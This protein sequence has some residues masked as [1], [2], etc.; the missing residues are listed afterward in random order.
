MEVDQ[1]GDHRH[2]RARP[3]ALA[4]RLVRDVVEQWMHRQHDVG[5]VLLQQVAQ[6]PAHGRAE[7]RSNG[8]ERRLRV[9]RVIDG[10]PRGARAADHGRVERGEA[11]D[12]GRSLPDQ[13]IGD[14]H[15]AGRVEQLQR[16]G[17]C[18]GRG[19]MAA[20]RVAEENQDSRRA[21]DG[22]R[23]ERRCGAGFGYLRRAALRRAI[24]RMLYE[25]SRYVMKT[26]AMIPMLTQS[27]VR[28]ASSPGE[29]APPP[30][31]R[32]CWMM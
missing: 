23:V 28:F 18:A 9:A 17:E 10:T 3:A 29:S 19:A 32:F 12:H 7:H 2:Q 8:G 31:L 22:C 14:R 27:M 26:M 21:A 13:R 15:D 24:H 30:G 6:H 5:V 16:V 1:V 25:D 20:A 4:D 11:A